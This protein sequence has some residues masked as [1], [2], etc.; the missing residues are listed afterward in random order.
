MDHIPPDHDTPTGVGRERHAWSS[1]RKVLRNRKARQLKAC[2]K[3]R[4]LI[5]A[6]PW[7]KRKSVIFSGLSGAGMA[8]ALF[9]ILFAIPIPLSLVTPRIAAGIEQQLGAGYSVSM[10][11]AV[12]EHGSDGLELRLSAF[13]I[14]DPNGAIVLNVPA[15]TIGLDGNFVLGRNVSVRHARLEQPNLTVRVESNGDVSLAGEEGAPPLFRLPSRSAA[16]STAPASLVGMFGVADGLLGEHGRLPLLQSIEIIDGRVILD[17][18]RRGQTDKME[19]VELRLS[20]RPQG[21]G[22]VLTGASSTMDANRSRFEATVTTGE[23]RKRLLD[24]TFYNISAGRLF[25]ETGIG[26]NRAKVDGALYG[27]IQLGVDE[28]EQLH[29][30]D[31]RLDVIGLDISVAM[32]QPVP[33]DPP[34]FELKLER[35]VL[36][37]KWDKNSRKINIHLDEYF[38]GLPA[39]KI[40]GEARLTGETLSGPWTYHAQGSNIDLPEA[41]PGLGRVRVEK[42]GMQGSWDFKTRQL[43][44]TSGTLYGPLLSL[45][46]GG[47]IIFDQPRPLADLGLAGGPTSV[48]ALLGVWPQFAGPR[49]RTWVKEHIDQGVISGFGLAIKGPL[50]RLPPELSRSTMIDLEFDQGRFHFMEDMSPLENAKGRLSVRDHKLDIFLEKGQLTPKDQKSLALSEGHF[51]SLNTRPDPFAAT[52]TTKVDGPLASVGAVLNSRLVKNFSPKG[53]DLVNAEGNVNGTLTL[54]ALMGGGRPLTDLRIGASATLTNLGVT[55]DLE[56]R[57]VTGGPLALDISQQAIAL[58][59]EASLD[60]SKFAL[61][62]RA[63]RDPRTGQPAHTTAAF[64]FDPSEMKAT[65]N[66]PLQIVGPVSMRVT[67]PSLTQMQVLDVQADITGAAVRGVPG[68]RKDKGQPGSAAFQAKLANNLWKFDNFNFSSASSQLTGT[69]DLSRDGGLDTA[70]FSTFRLNSGDDARLDLARYGT[71]GYS[72]TV[73]GASL[74][75]RTLLKNTFSTTSLTGKPIDLKLDA[76]LGT[77]LG[78]NGE[79]LSGLDLNASRSNGKIT[80]F[81]LNSIAGSGSFKGSLI[82][83][84]R[85]VL[86]MQAEDAGSVFRFF[87]FYKN[88][89]GGVMNLQ[90]IP[91][92]VVSGQLAIRD[93]AVANEKALAAMT[94]AAKQGI[95]ASTGARFS[96]METTFTLSGGRLS[97][98]DTAIWGPD[99][100]ATLEGEVNF[101]ANRV[102]MRGTFVPA[103]ALNN[104]FSKIPVLG[105]ILGGGRNEGLLGITFQVTGA[106]DN[107][108]L[109]VNPVSA[110]APGFLRKIFEFQK[111]D[112]PRSVTPAPSA[113]QTQSAPARRSRANVPPP[114]GAGR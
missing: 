68:L 47:N 89:R 102:D 49:I 53:V 52:L 34:P 25:Y 32:P 82:N 12:V 38:K 99:V 93:F 72:L 21:D 71:G 10:A 101:A 46:G 55:T 62:A 90:I 110:V 29:H 41:Q 84:G 75:V 36:E 81:S 87:N 40:R 113:P 37:G 88:L 100:G 15:A 108:N 22:Y 33:P 50:G 64:T 39:A 77:V 57:R 17:D 70:Q 20:R 9:A 73:R 58:S 111:S 69:I 27:H 11:R 85:G 13:T 66:S 3:Q 106:F 54:S 19:H 114:G 97:L 67:V 23:Q 92:A 83:K 95:P 96:K 5:A 35:T 4:R 42:L 18:Q 63:E 112:E 56:G 45:A 8:V 14:K 103:Y 26:A 2:R 28:K 30:L 105:F 6:R 1:M 104:F 78:N 91:A 31:T 65:A 43:I 60:G 86:G 80:A 74:D 7:Y 76:K 51:E 61:E 98:M 107:P 44:M 94:T 48:S 59:G 16:P 24:F 109:R 79:A